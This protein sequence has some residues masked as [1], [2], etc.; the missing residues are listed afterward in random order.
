MMFAGG[1][2]VVDAESRLS[3]IDSNFTN[4][5]GGMMGGV[6]A[7]NSG[8]IE[9]SGS[10]F[11]RAES[12]MAG[13]FI[14]AGGSSTLTLRDTVLRDIG[15]RGSWSWNSILLYDGPTATFSRC[16]FE[17]SQKGVFY[18]AKVRAPHPPTRTT[19]IPL[20]SPRGLG[21]PLIQCPPRGQRRRPSSTTATLRALSK[22][23][24]LSRPSRRAAPSASPARLSSAAALTIHFGAPII[25]AV[26]LSSPT[27]PM[28][29]DPP[30]TPMT[31]A[32]NLVTARALLYQE[33]LSVAFTLEQVIA[34][35]LPE[36][37]ITDTKVCII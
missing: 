10:R 12:L 22:T 27:A 17:A 11:E 37:I 15:T 35:P 9:I 21:L 28:C 34:L 23:L 24:V 6:F 36:L 30:R 7:S 13:S 14:A 18:V 16:R 33:I 31:A 5:R 19:T 2:F 3:V 26:S 32:T 8:I 25:D 29:V 20:V 1:A 4:C